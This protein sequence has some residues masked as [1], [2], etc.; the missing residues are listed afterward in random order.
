MLFM[1]VFE[2]ILMIGNNTINAIRLN[3]KCLCM[4]IYV[5]L[6]TVTFGNHWEMLTA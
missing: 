6:N 3:P 1:L 5:Y 4:K 2:Q